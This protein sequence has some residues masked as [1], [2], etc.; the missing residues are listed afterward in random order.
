MTELSAA[1]LKMDRSS[2]HL[3][4]RPRTFVGTD[5]IFYFPKPGGRKITRDRVFHRAGGIADLSAL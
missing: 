3:G 5:H 2:C 1:F 4:L